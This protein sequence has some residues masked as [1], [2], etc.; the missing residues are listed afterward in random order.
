MSAT[1]EKKLNKLKVEAKETYELLVKSSDLFN[2]VMD[3]EDTE[4]KDSL[5]NEMHKIR[6]MLKSKIKDSNGKMVDR[7]NTEDHLRKVNKRLKNVSKDM[8]SLFEPYE[9]DEE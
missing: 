1:F 7:P 6:K 8:M 5:I 4:W 3:E 2:E 9:V